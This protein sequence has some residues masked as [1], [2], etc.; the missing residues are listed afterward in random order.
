M[1]HLRSEDRAGPWIAAIAWHVAI[2]SVRVRRRQEPLPDEVPDH[3]SA[4]GNDAGA[5][6]V[7]AALRALPKT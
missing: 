4:A 3:R 2:D 6:Q 7:L 1:R 5:H